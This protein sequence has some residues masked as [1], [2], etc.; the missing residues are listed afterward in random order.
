M[1]WMP[2]G[3]VGCRGVILVGRGDVNTCKHHQNCKAGHRSRSLWVTCG[4]TCRN[5]CRDPDLQVQVTCSYRSLRIW[6]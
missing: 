1:P 6:V 3:R 5:T 4:F 2:D